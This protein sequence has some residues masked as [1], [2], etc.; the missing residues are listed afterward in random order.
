MAGR[1]PLMK[2]FFVAASTVGLALLGF[3]L[4]TSF[5][6][7][8]ALLFVVG[9]G[10][11]VAITVMN[12]ALQEIVEERLRGRTMSLFMTA[13]WGG[14]RIGALPIGFVAGAWSASLAVGL[15]AAAL[16]IS[17]VPAARNRALWAVD[18]RGEAPAQPIPAPDAEAEGS[19]SAATVSGA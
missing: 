6:L 5:P 2:T 1:V 15:A 12:T 10:S 14:W 8:L 3:V 19:S 11:T 17:L 4:T 7:A 9:G 13:T 18:A 16:L